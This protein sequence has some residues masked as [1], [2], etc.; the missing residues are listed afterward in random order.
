VGG[1]SGQ[2]VGRLRRVFDRFGSTHEDFAGLFWSHFQAALEW[3]DA[4]MWLE[5]AVQS[6]WSVAE[7]RR[8]RIETRG[9]VEGAD[10][11]DEPESGELDEDFSEEAGDSLGRAPAAPSE[12]PALRS[13]PSADAEEDGADDDESPPTA[14]DSSPDSDADE[15]RGAPFAHLEELPP[16]MAEAFEAFKLAIV[17]HR[18]ARWSE[19]RRED[20]LA[21]LAALGELALAPVE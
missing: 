17:R 6:G 15:P 12:S 7:M 16:D 5:G 2:H 4:E 14:G 21:A 10:V 13:R 3:D 11:A 19:V 8:Q 1:V 20:V 18:L 9:A